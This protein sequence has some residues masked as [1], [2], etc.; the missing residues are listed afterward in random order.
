M[1]V[2]LKPTGGA[3]CKSDKGSKVNIFFDNDLSNIFQSMEYHLPQIQ[4]SC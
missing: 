2:R 4:N 1:K 3:G